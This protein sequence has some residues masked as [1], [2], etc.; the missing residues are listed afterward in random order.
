MNEKTTR[1]A[2]GEFLREIGSINKDV[3]VLDADLSGSTQTRKFADKYH[4]RFFNVGCA[5]QNLIATAAG[6]ANSG[7]IVFASTYAI[8]VCRAWDQIRT[9]VAHDNLNV[10]IV[11]THAGLTNAPDGASHHSLEDIALM[12]VIPSIK[13]IV[14]CD[15][16]ET[17]NALS[18]VVNE[19]GPAY[20]RLRRTVEPIVEKNYDFEIGKAP[21]IRDGSDVTV[22]AT[23]MMVAKSLEAA[24]K[25]NA[26]GIQVRV[27][28]MHT[29][30]PIDEREIIRAGKETMG[31]V[32]AE[33]HSVIGGLG[34]AVAEVLSENYPMRL[35]RVGVQDKFGTSAR[36]VE[37]LLNAYGLT[38]EDIVKAVKSVCEGGK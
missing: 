3:V 35:R 19:K 26:E 30:K 17:K 25:L 38:S 32:T 29:I 13:I 14:P 8:F 20:I 12:R 37:E 36:V 2:Y 10:K 21:I 11:V 16:E 27:I 28:N 31:I 7:K 1:D 24:E 33:N 22:I 34:G 9:L 18:A 6:L 4:E 5:E 15:A 23:G